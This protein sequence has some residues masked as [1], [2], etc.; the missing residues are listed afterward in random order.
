M[1]DTLVVR[2]TRFNKKGVGSI[3]ALAKAIKGKNYTEQKIKEAFKKLISKEEYDS[4]DKAE[5]ISWLCHL[6]IVPK[7]PQKTLEK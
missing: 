3:I 4:C 5:L 1:S 2:F 7:Q 6:N